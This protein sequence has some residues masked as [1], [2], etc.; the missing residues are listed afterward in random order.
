M[1]LRNTLLASALFLS[2][3]VSFAEDVT[4][5]S[6]PSTIDPKTQQLIQLGS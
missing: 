1:I 2:A 6:M 4:P 3:S 5:S